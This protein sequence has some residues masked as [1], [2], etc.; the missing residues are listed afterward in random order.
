M[1]ID[2]SL[3]DSCCSSLNRLVK[4]ENCMY[5]RCEKL[6]SFLRGIREVKKKLIVIYVLRF[7]P[8]QLFVHPVSMA[9]VVKLT[10]DGY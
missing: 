6:H 2:W 7:I 10:K 8:R 1:A 3:I 5:T 4:T 9:A